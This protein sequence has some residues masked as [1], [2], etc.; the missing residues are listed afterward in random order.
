MSA[1]PDARLR[2][3]SAERLPAPGEPVKIM[4]AMRLPR[5]GKSRRV[6]RAFVLFV[7][8]LVALLALQ[9]SGLPH[10]IDD[11]ADSF[12]VAE[13]G[14]APH[15]CDND[16]EDADCPPGCPSCHCVH[17]NVLP[18]AQTADLFAWLGGLPGSE[19]AELTYDSTAPPQPTLASVFRPPRA[20][21]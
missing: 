7:R 21:A 17:S 5:V 14:I 20:I 12:A 15:D 16:R 19:L 6:R 1:V 10:A 2:C 11:F 4:A 3:T 18:S 9:I 13:S 8:T